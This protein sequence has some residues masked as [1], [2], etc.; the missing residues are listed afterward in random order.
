MID[1]GRAVGERL[2]GGGSSKSHHEARGSTRVN[3]H[4]LRPNLYSQDRSL[5]SLVT[6]FKSVRTHYS[7]MK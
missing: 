3:W 7:G 1:L 5:G 6:S 4:E 2:K